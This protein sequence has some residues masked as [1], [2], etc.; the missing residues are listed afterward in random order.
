[1]LV[2]DSDMIL[3][4]PGHLAHRLAD[5]L[6]LTVVELPL[7]VPPLAPAMIWHERVHG[8]PAHIWVRQQLVDIVAS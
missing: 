8:D 3:T 4:L 5:K 6:P 1:M 2:A 7:E